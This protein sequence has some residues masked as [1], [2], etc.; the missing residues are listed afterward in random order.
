MGPGHSRPGPFCMQGRRRR[1]HGASTPFAVW[2]TDLAP[3]CQ[4][5][6]AHCKPERSLLRGGAV[7]ARVF[8]DSTGVRWEVLEVRR[9]SQKALAVSAGLELG[10]LAFGSGTERR[11]LAPIPDDW[12]TVDDVT[13]ARL[14]ALAQVVRDKAGNEQRVSGA[15]ATGTVVGADVRT[16]AASSPEISGEEGDATPGASSR[17]RVPRIRSPR[18]LSPRAAGGALAILTTASSDD[19]VQSTVREYARQAREVDLPAIEAMVQLKGLLA[20]VYT[21]AHP[22]ARDLR[23]VRRWFVEAFY[24]ERG[25]PDADT[26]DQ[27]R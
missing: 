27:S 3:G 12:Q 25:V 20:R 15:S 6:G 11:R 21:D 22:E 4:V 1:S 16:D 18:E 26:S 10:W 7:T 2:G 9:S 5:S 19:D 24:F 14:C 13:L 17:K 8:E 23:A